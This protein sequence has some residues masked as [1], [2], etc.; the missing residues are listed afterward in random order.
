MKV[1]QIARTLQQLSRIV[2]TC[3]AAFPFALQKI[4]QPS[5]NTRCGIT[6]PPL[7]TLRPITYLGTLDMNVSTKICSTHYKNV[8][9]DRITLSNTSFWS[10]RFTWNANK[11]D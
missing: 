7:A 10:E 11:Q 1:E 6:E 8:W 4:K 9:E 5:A 2:F 3:R